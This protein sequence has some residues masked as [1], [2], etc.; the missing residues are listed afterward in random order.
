MTIVILK[1]A[2]VI[3]KKT[4]ENPGSI[5]GFVKRGWVKSSKG[6]IFVKTNLKKVKSYSSNTYLSNV[7]STEIAASKITMQMILSVDNY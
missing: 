1:A 2:R 7:F 3:E 5:L 4:Q 6:I